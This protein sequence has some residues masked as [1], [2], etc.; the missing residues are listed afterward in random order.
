V[1]YKRLFAAVIFLSLGQLT[2]SSGDD[3][4]EAIKKMLENGSFGVRVIEINK[5]PMR[6]VSFDEDIP[7]LTA[8]CPEC[9]RISPLPATGISQIAAAFRARGSVLENGGTEQEALIA[10]NRALLKMGAV[11]VFTN[12][13]SDCSL[14]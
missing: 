14:G 13:H 7:G 11:T 5:D 2:Y 8:L 12:M 1:N 10:R 4:S 9:G 6:K 3:K